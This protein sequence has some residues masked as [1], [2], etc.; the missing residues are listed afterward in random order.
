MGVFPA[1]S[2]GPAAR[3]GVHAAMNLAQGAVTQ[4]N[5]LDPDSF[6]EFVE[7]LLTKIEAAMENQVQTRAAKAAAINVLKKKLPPELLLV[8]TFSKQDL[9]KVSK[10]HPQ[11]HYG[12]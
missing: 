7:D 2:A 5:Q 9:Y 12:W 4:Q 3:A 1:K 10:H 8:S 6:V 11:N